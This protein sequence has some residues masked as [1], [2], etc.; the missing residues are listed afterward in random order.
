MKKKPSKT[1]FDRYVEQAL[2]K[3]P[4]MREEVARAE[5]AWDIAFQI[6]D[7]RKKRGLTQEKLASLAGISQ[8]NIA[9]IERADYQNYTLRTLEKV[10]RVLGAQVDVVIVP[11]EKVAGYRQQWPRPVF[12]LE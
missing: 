11:K 2:G 4:V 12:N 9:R 6:R 10:A 1:S 3:H 7:L 5:R 8:P